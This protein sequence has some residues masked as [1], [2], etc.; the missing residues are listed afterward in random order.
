[1]SEWVPLSR[2]DDD[3]DEYHGP[4][5]GV[6]PWLEASIVDWVRNCFINPAGGYRIF[7][8]RQAE[9]TLRFQLE[10]SQSVERAIYEKTSRNFC[11]NHTASPLLAKFHL[12]RYPCSRQTCIGQAQAAKTA[13]ARRVR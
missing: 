8:M 1:M 12:S 11:A 10:S 3:D 5:D 13:L 2:R 7:L 9:R 6:P 4:F